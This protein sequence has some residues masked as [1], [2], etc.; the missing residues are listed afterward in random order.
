MF[1][2]AWIKVAVV[3]TAFKLLFVLNHTLGPR[4]DFFAQFAVF[5][6]GISNGI[7]DLVLYLL[8]E[9]AKIS[10]KNR[11]VLVDSRT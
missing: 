2:K 6:R 8:K 7:C 4:N 1:F 5:Q 9:G 3:L 10:S 11:M